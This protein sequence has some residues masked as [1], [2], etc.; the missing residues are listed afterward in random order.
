MK[1]SRIKLYHNQYRQIFYAKETQTLIIYWHGNVPDNE[2]LRHIDYMQEL[3]KIYTIRH[4]EAHTKKARF[5]SLKPTR[6]FLEKVL[7]KIYQQGGRTFTLI[8]KP[9]KNQLFVMN[10][11]LNAIR[12]LGI[13]M[14]FKL[15][16]S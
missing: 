10:A 11:Y 16:T 8:Q 4:I 9:M 7:T 12:S 14:E 2:Q 3:I 15:I 1:N 5:L 13:N 6:I